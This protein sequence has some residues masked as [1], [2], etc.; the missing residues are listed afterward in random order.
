MPARVL[1][2]A[3]A[4]LFDVPFWISLPVAGL[5]Y[6]LLSSGRALTGGAVLFLGGVLAV[7]AVIVI[8][9]E[10]RRSSGVTRPSLLLSIRSK[11]WTAIASASPRV[12]FPSRLLSAM[13]II[14][15]CPRPAI[16]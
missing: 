10:A 15:A 8:G 5:A 12:I 2:A 7:L 14:R 13:T 4:A 11:C 3:L 6:A 16:R 1:T 9:I